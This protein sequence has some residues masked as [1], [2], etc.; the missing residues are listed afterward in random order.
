MSAARQIIDPDTGIGL[1]WRES[2][3]PKPAAKAGSILYHTDKPGDKWETDGTSWT[4]TEF[5]GA[6]ASIDYSDIPHL[7]SIRTYSSAVN[8]DGP[9]PTNVMDGL[10]NLNAATV[11]LI[12]RDRGAVANQC[13]NVIRNPADE[14][15]AAGQLAGLHSW[16]VDPGGLPII[17][18]GTPSAPV[19][20]IYWK[21]DLDETG[22][23]EL[24][25]IIQGFA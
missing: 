8:A 16:R 13:L 10:T 1:Y 6:K 24:S 3:E 17:F 25:V 7:E 20:D 5:S 21:A 2:T 22:E 23:T 11:I 15:D 9:A 4:Q 14:A 18:R 12:Y 19:N